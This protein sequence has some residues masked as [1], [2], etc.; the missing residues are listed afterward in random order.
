MEEERKYTIYLHR[1]PNGKCYV[2]MTSQSINQRWKNGLGY[3]NN[4]DFYSD[5]LEYGW[6]N[7]EHIVLEEGISREDACESEKYNIKKYNCIFPN[8]YNIAI[9]GDLP[10]NL[11]SASSIYQLSKNGNI[12]K[13]W[14]SMKEASDFLKITKTAI[15]DCCSMK[16]KLKSAGGF[17]WIYEKDYLNMTKENYDKLIDELN[18][19]KTTNKPVLQIDKFGKI[20]KKWKSICEASNSL[21][22]SF[23]A[24]SSCCNLNY[25][26]SKTC[27]DYIWLKKEDYD[28]MSNEEFNNEIK[29]RNENNRYSK[30]ANNK[31]SIANKG[32]IRTE[33]SKIKM[34][35]T[36]KARFKSGELV[37]YMKGKKHLKESIYKMSKSSLGN[38]AWKYVDYSKIKGENNPNAKW[39]VCDGLIFKM[40]ISCSNYYGVSKSTISNA[41]TGN[42][43]MPQKYID[44]GL[45]YYNPE[46][47]KDLPIYQKPIDNDDNV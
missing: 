47:D 22:C 36:R 40:C 24:I 5:I 3:K 15:C 12:I 16:M 2:G 7:I 32:K 1:C 44:R 14:C 26:K 39:I 11:G 27:I 21:G 6:D 20:I 9:G 46:T 38:D 4:K 42:R 10:W 35:L 28:C 45:R 31:I 43:K 19:N 18:K 25:K 29:E 37:P 34:S 8:G 30:E 13:K 23:G 41:I 33:E 17:Y